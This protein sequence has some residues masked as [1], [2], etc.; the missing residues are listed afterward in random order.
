MLPRCVSCSTE[1]R[2]SKNGAMLVIPVG[3]RPYKIYEGDCYICDDCDMEIMM[4]FSKEPQYGPYHLMEKEAYEV[5]SEAFERIG[6]HCVVEGFSST[7]KYLK[8]VEEEM[9]WGDET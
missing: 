1:M 6:Q 8:L 7:L 9:G 5:I 2:C 3:L 4:G